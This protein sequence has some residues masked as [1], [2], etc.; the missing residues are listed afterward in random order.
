MCSSAPLQN[1]QEKTV[2][3]IEMGVEM[4]IFWKKLDRFSY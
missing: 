3:S 1:K 2:E 4:I